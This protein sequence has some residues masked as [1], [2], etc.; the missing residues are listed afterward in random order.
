[1]STPETVE[2]GSVDPTPPANEEAEKKPTL[3]ARLKKQW[4]LLGLIF[5][6]V[7]ALPT[8][9]IGKGDGPLRMSFVSKV[10]QKTLQLS[11]FPFKSEKPKTPIVTDIQT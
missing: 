4:F 5:S 6:V 11:F 2:A 7:I 8:A 3:A 9:E 1:M 10:L